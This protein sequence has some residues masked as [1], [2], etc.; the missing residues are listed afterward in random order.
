MN[1]LVCTPALVVVLLCGCAN[2]SAT[3]APTTPPEDTAQS[4]SFESRLLEIAASYQ[5]FGRATPAAR[6]A[7]MYCRPYVPPTPEVALSRSTDGATHGR[8]LYALFAK[9]LLQSGDYVVKGQPSPVG[10]VIVKESWV[11]EEMT[12]DGRPLEPVRRK[13]MVRQ[14]EALVERD[15]VFVPY[16]RRGDRLYHAREKGP[17]FVMFKTDPQT[18]GTDEGWVYGTLTPDGHQVTA[19]GRVES[20]MKCHREAPHDR[21]FGLPDPK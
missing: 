20:C 3:N 13:V 16:A 9:D 2:N 4:Q 17:L 6:W 21:L 10:Q 18:P 14:G 12:D 11:P 7:P 5:S 1:R 8:K 15:D 19:A